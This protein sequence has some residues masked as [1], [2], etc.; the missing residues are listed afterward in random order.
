MKTR[1]LFILVC[2]AALF[3][4][5]VPAAWADDLAVYAISPA[6]GNTG[7]T[8][9]CIVYGSSSTRSVPSALSPRSLCMTA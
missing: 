3:A 5:A 9:D 7:T 8:Q 6:S 4:I 2:V 1:V